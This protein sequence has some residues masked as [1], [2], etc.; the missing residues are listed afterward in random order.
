MFD[1]L[2]YGDFKLILKDHPRL[3]AYQRAYEGKCVTVCC[4]FSN[5]PVE[6]PKEFAN[7][8]LFG[9]QQKTD[10][11]EPYGAVVLHKLE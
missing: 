2:K 7:P 6:L 5:E 3:F 4:N 11:L 1:I 10:I 8:F 9:T